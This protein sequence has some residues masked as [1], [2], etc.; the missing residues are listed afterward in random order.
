MTRAIAWSLALISALCVIGDTLVVS[1]YGSLWSTDT[2]GLH[3]WPFVD[4]A[5]LG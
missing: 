5:G 4:L 2:L 1:A 3:G